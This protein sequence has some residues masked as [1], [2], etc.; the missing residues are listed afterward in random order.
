MA[1]AGNPSEGQWDA[2][3][4]EISRDDEMLHGLVQGWKPEGKAAIVEKWAKVA[5]VVNDVTGAT[6]KKNGDQ[7]R[8]AW[9]SLKSR[10][11]AKYRAVARPLM[12]KGESPP[13]PIS[14][15]K[16][17]VYQKVIEATGVEAALQSSIKRNSG[18]AAE[19]NEDDPQVCGAAEGQDNDGYQVIGAVEGIENLFANLEMDSIAVSPL[20]GKPIAESQCGVSEIQWKQEPVSDD[21]VEVVYTQLETKCGVSEIQWKEEPVS[22]D[23]VE[24]VYTQVAKSE[25][26]GVEGATRV[27]AED[28]E[29][30]MQTCFNQKTKVLHTPP[31]GSGLTPTSKKT[32]F[33]TAVTGGASN[34][35]GDA[36]IRSLINAL[37][38][39]TA[40]TRDM[41]AFLKM[42]K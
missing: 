35:L 39:N 14:V 42:K 20:A 28:S 25:E 5:K 38:R 9:N 7:W 33:P 22:D 30:D 17:P 1:D 34:K 18:N 40:A 24:V 2:L 36:S 23:E 16:N 32:L 12:E 10:A 29:L 41:I 11:R 15:L 19:M 3:I 13:S 26:T 4:A 8:N 6:A 27:K 21:E 31:R 37:D